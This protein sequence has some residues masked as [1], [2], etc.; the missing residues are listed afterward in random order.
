VEVVVMM[1]MMM[2][3]MMMTTIVI[4]PTYCPQ[5][6]VHGLKVWVLLVEPQQFLLFAHPVP[7]CSDQHN[8]MQH[9]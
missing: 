6:L 7:Y 1:M 3:M 8:I 2:M 5:S 9:H 4:A